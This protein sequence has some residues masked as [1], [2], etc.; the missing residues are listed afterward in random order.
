MEARRRKTRASEQRAH[1]SKRQKTDS[2]DVWMCNTF[3]SSIREFHF[4]RRLS[5]VVVANLELQ[6]RLKSLSGA[7]IV[8]AAT[9]IFLLELERRRGFEFRGEGMQIAHMID[10]AR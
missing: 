1:N 4:G 5:G 2:G 8:A 3:R 9:A 6:L 10:G 7:Q